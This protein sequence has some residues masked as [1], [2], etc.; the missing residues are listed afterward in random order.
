MYVGSACRTG[1][2]LK[3]QFVQESRF[4]QSSTTLFRVCQ[5]LLK[6]V[7]PAHIYQH[8]STARA[9]VDVTASELHI[10]RL[11]AGL[12]V[13]VQRLAHSNILLILHQSDCMERTVAV[14][15]LHH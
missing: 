6:E 3:D 5:P 12:S 9:H 11:I 8:V 13:S 2:W 14:S 1:F 10:V 7:R 15:G 4:S